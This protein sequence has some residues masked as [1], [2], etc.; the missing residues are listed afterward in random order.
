MT[1]TLNPPGP[2][3]F[4]L[5]APYQPAPVPSEP[6]GPTSSASASSTSSTIR[7]P[8]AVGAVAL[9]SVV[10]EAMEIAD[11]VHGQSR[12]DEIESNNHSRLRRAVVGGV[13]DP[14]IARRRAEVARS[15]QQRNW[16]AIFGVVMGV[17]VATVALAFLAS[18]WMSMRTVVIEG[19]TPEVAKQIQSVVAPRKGVAMLRLPM[20]RIQK[21]IG[22]LA[23]VDKVSVA[24]QWPETIT[25]RVTVRAP[26]ALIRQNGKT[27]LVDKTGQKLPSRPTSSLPVVA[28]VNQRADR[29]ALEEARSGAL[30]VLNSLDEPTRRA[31]QQVDNFGSDFVLRIG[32]TSILVGR[33]DDLAAKAMLI[34][35]LYRTGQLPPKGTIDVTIP[36]AVVLSK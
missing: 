31:V 23:D 34:S 11:D 36:D 12:S 29:L 18:P 28:L 8:G 3:D 17:I 26:F 10:V 13:M 27:R 22:S 35:S 14:A 32:R 30:A 4:E 20:A 5:L 21:D 24:K 33:A 1:I 6:G 7:R 25:I 16:K 2:I 15:N 19:A 9:R